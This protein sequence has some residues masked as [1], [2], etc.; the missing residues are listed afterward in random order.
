MG[1][2]LKAEIKA[3]MDANPGVKYTEARRAVLK[4]ASHPEA[5]TVPQDVAEVASSVLYT[6]GVFG[7]SREWYPTIVAVPEWAVGDII[8]FGGQYG[9]YIGEGRVLSDGGRIHVAELGSTDFEVFRSEPP[10]TGDNFPHIG[11]MEH[12]TEICAPDIERQWK[13]TEF[14]AALNVPIGVRDDETGR[15]EVVSLNLAATAQGGNGPHGIIRGVTGSGK[16]VLASN[17][18]TALAAQYSPTKVNIALMDF[19]PHSESMITPYNGDVPP[20]VVYNRVLGGNYTDPDTNVESMQEFISF[21]SDELNRRE[22]LLHH[23]ASRDIHE[24]RGRRAMDETLEPIPYLLVIVDGAYDTPARS[25]SRGVCDLLTRVFRKGRSLGVHVLDI[26]QAGDLYD[27][28]AYLNYA[29]AFKCSRQQSRF[30]IG[31]PSAGEL[32]SVGDGSA[33]VKYAHFDGDD[34]IARVRVLRLEDNAYVS[35]AK[36]FAEMKSLSETWS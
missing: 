10:R 22:T 35:R 8:K 17:I 11:L 18:V 24:Y 21:V 3:Y 23:A 32:T 33:Y 34:E 19:H 9:V 4:G 29:V 16:S 13:R 6:T 20:H 36:V 30:T 25:H 27:H 15:G 26:D 1:A 14:T 2:Q 7:H 31:N 12:L 5:V 28:S